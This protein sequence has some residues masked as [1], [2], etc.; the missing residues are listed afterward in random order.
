VHEAEAEVRRRAATKAALEAALASCRHEEREGLKRQLA[1][2]AES[3]EDA[4]RGL[5][6]A[7]GASRAAQALERRISD[8]AGSRVPRAAGEL[9]RKLDAL[10]DYY[11]V[12][13]PT[14]GQP[15]AIP[16]AA[17]T[18]DTT[19]DDFGVPGIVNVPIAH[20]SFDDNPI[21]DGYQRGGANLGD[22]RWAV[23][24]WET[25]VRP[26]VLAGKTR[27]DFER[28]DAET[29]STGLRR[30][31][32]VYDMFLG[33]DPIQ[34]ARRPNGSLDVASGRHR[35]AVAKQLGITHLPGRL[36]G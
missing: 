12:P 10:A 30:T 2:A 23:E 20:A 35:V 15:P 32:G 4:R 25:V 24:K 19:S 6:Q 3:L 28:R 5:Q 11:A 8:S 36:H 16:I 34:F 18:G 26:G 9:A 1:L 13:L 27:E 17:S 22:Y 21:L 14:S 7:N 31:A 33:G 29:G